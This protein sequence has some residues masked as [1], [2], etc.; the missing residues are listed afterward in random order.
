MP[1]CAEKV[2]STCKVCT[3]CVS[4]Y[5]HHFYCTICKVWST[6]KVCTKCGVHIAH[7]ITHHIAHHIAHHVVNMHTTLSAH[8]TYS[9]LNVVC[10]L[11]TTSSAHLTYVVC[12]ICICVDMVHA[13]VPALTHSTYRA[14]QFRLLVNVDHP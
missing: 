13:C 10:L 11:H 5:T 9:A 4:E 7:H 1:V 6:C 8:L 2:C 12:H 14:I 3:K